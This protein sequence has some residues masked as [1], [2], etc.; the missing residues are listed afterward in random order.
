MKTPSF[1]RNASS[2]QRRRF[3]T[4]SLGNQAL[5]MM[6]SVF[7]PV[8]TYKGWTSLNRHVVKGSKAKVIYVPMFRK[9]INDNGEKEKRLSGFKLVPCMFGFSETEGEEL[10]PWEPPTWSKDKAMDTLGI[11]EVAYAMIDPN[12]QGYSQASSV[13]INPL[14]RYPFKTL[15]H[16]IGHVTHGHTTSDGMVEY[17]THRGVMDCQAEATAYLVLNELDALH[18]FDASESRHYISTWLKGETPSETAIKRIFTVADKIIRAGR[19]D[20]AAELAEAS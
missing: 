15:I 20:A 17:Q 14:A 13:A 10:P 4:L 8:H 6:Q 16:E 18:Q 2:I 1:L 11:S 7:E 9:E 3:R 5:L 12:C 19:E